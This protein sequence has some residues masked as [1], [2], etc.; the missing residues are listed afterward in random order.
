M[1]ENYTPQFKAKI[2][3]EALQARETD[4]S[5][6]NAY[7]VHPV[8]LSRWKKQLERNAAQVFGANNDEVDEL[9][10]QLT[11]LRN[12]VSRAEAESAILRSVFDDVADI[13]KKVALANKFK[14]VYGLNVVCDI[15]GLP[16]S[17]YYYR[18]AEE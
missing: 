4:T 14:D 7:G 17:T 6:A 12:R 16:K 13:D 11:E 2:V 15:L 1:S 10:D 9:A 18:M 3:L 5:I 8:T